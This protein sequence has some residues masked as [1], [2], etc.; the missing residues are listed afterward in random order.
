[1]SPKLS[2]VIASVNGLPSIVECLESLEAL[3]ERDQMEILVLD[4]CGH[5]TAQTIAQ[6]FPRVSLHAGR[7]ER[8]IPE[9]R[10]QGMRAARGE[11]VAVIEDHCFVTPRWAAEILRF[12]HSPYGV[13]GGP[14]ENASDRVLDWAFYL[15]EYTAAIPPLPEGE[16]DSVPGNNA[17]YRRSVLPLAE[18]AWARLWENFLQRELR[19]R[20]VRVFLNPAMLVHHKKRFRL[21]EMLAQ[22]F[23]YSRSL[24]AMRGAR[25]GAAGRLLRAAA[26]L[27]LPSVL[28]GRVA[29][30]L[31]RKRRN[32]REFLLGLPA[33]ALFV[34]AWAAGDIA[35]YLAGAGNSLQRVE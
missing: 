3:P 4:R 24:A 16:T 34:V 14:V 32:P 10:W 17:A 13:V 22:R 33:M 29:L 28:L 6:R 5:E 9:L 19:S 21:G 7:R 8:S 25:M 23:Y 15:A 27:V 12:A 20:G 18:P 1:M 2:V 11:I 35:G 31:A 26:S 30:N